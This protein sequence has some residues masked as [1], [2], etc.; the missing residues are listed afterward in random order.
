M[1]LTTKD[2]RHFNTDWLDQEERMKYAQIEANQ[3]QAN[4]MN[5]TLNEPTS[6][7]SS[8][9]YIYDKDYKDAQEAAHE[10]WTK[11]QS[12][13]D[14]MKQIREERDKELIVDP[15]LGR[16]LSEVLGNY[17]DKGKVLDEKYYSLMS[18]RSQAEKQHQLATDVLQSKSSEHSKIQKELYENRKED[19]VS[20]SLKENYQGFEISKSTTPYVDEK[21]AKGEAYIVEMS[22]KQYL[23]E[24][25]Y[26]IFPNSTLERQVQATAANNYANPKKYAQ[27]MREGTKFHTPYL[28][29]E[30][31][32]QE[33]RNRAV[34]AFI[35]G[36]ERI[37]VIIIP[38]KRRK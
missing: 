37:P 21:L 32:A 11:L 20:T 38:K 36:Y 8:N 26:H 33:G 2:G 25:G 23:Q 17:T 9:S 31:G 5:G 15:S 35:N 14:E 30:S 19:T 16:Q 24:A 18:E 12:L 3:M 13:G 4:S 22:P 28:N 10:A 27:Q 6:L 1:W 34:A 7:I 29:Y